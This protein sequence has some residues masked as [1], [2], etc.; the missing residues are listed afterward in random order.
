MLPVATLPDTRPRLF[1]RLARIVS[2]YTGK[3]EKHALIIDQRFDVGL[4]IFVLLRR[5]WTIPVL[6]IR[7]QDEA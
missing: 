1:R 7:S 6:F 4:P 5:L 3:W 2:F